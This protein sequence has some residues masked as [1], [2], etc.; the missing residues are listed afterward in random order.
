[1]EKHTLIA[2]AGLAVGLGGSPLSFA[3]ETARAPGKEDSGKTAQVS[4]SMTALGRPQ[5]ATEGPLR[6][7]ELSFKLDVRL[8]RSLYMGDRWVSPATYTRVGEGKDCIVE[9]RAYGLTANHKTVAIK[10]T[11]TSADPEIASVSSG[12]AGEVK[13]NI[14]RAGE[15]IVE[16]VSHGVSKRLSIKVMPHGNTLKADI[17]QQASRRQ[18][19]I[20]AQAEGQSPAGTRSTAS[21]PQSSASTSRL[22][23]PDTVPS[24]QRTNEKAS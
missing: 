18:S 10:P 23:N 22:N 14:K 24:S 5:P 9:I 20:K 13:L 2:I 8:T 7:I 19:G 21:P 4:P 12:H 15:T 11:W 16:V 6:E 1:M 3:Y 17:T